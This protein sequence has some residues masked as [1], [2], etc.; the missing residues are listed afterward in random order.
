[1]LEAHHTLTLAS[2]EDGKPWSAAVF[3][4]SDAE[5]NLYFVSDR[6]TRHAREILANPHVALAINA[7]VDNW[8]D[9]RGLQIEGTAVP[10]EGVERTRALALYLAKFA[11]VKALFETPRSADEQTIAGRLKATGFW[12]ITPAYIRVIDNS[13]GFGFR[14]ELTNPG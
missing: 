10:I 8:N 4:A 7:D 6:R 9:V 5:F 13:R 14:L 2:C 11:S 12:R 1:M 3:Y